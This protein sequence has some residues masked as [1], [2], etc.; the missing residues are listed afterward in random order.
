[1]ETSCTFTVDEFVGGE[2]KP[3][4]S[5]ALD[6]GNARMVKLYEG[7]LS[8]RSVTQF[9]FCFDAESGIGSYVATESFDGSVDDRRGTFNFI[10]SATTLGHGERLHELF[11]IVPHSGTGQLTGIRGTGSLVIDDDG[12]HRIN[13]DYSFA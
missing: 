13:L 8:G 5:T 6:T 1:M 10:H 9:S 3:E 11:L 12:T 7:G 2:W 4:I